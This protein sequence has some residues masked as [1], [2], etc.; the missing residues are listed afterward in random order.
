[1]SRSKINSKLKQAGDL[2]VFEILDNETVIVKR[3]N[4]LDKEYLK[5]LNH[6]LSEWQSKDDEEAYND[7]QTL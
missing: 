2:L 4:A 7:L 6:T 3:A 1:M 5:A